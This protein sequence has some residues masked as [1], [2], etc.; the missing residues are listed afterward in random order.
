MN[1]RAALLGG[2]YGEKLALER[3]ATAARVLKIQGDY[4]MKE[5]LL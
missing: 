2:T 3:A 5:E 1:K 4:L